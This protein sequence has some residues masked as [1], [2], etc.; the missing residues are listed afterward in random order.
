MQA[1]ENATTE[2][3]ASATWG[4]AF[5]GDAFHRVEC[6]W[7]AAVG[8]IARELGLA[9]RDELEALRH[10]VAALEEGRRSPDDRPAAAQQAERLSPRLRE[11]L[12]RASAAI[13]GMTAPRRPAQPRS[14]DDTDRTDP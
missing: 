3:S 14:A 2:G 5:W 8:R 13:A 6:L 4:F 1:T 11:S 12:G 10:R 7:R 9:T